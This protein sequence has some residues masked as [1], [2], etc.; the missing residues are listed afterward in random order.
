VS[1]PETR[2]GYPFGFRC[3]RS[4]NC[5]A[6][7]DGIVRVDADEIRALAAQVGL[8][9]AAFRS[10]YVARSG[11]RLLDAPGGRCVFLQDG[12]EATCTVHPARPR[13]CRDWPFW[14]ALRDD[15]AALAAARRWCP[16]I[17]PPEAERPPGA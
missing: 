4:G 1:A 11:D 6:R 10:R 2:A 15:P 13:Q 3:R 14:P 8:T 5:C 7:P 12:V 9:E 16:G 17:E